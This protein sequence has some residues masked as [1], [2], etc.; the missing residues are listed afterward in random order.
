MLKKIVPLLTLVLVSRTVAAQDYWQQEVQYTIDVAL[1][2]Q[3]HSLKGSLQLNYTNHSPDTLRYIWFHLWPNA[4]K[5]ENTALARQL[6]ADKEGKKKLKNRKSAGSIDGLAFA[7]NGKKVTTAPD[8]LN[9][10]DVTKVVLNEPLLPGQSADITTPFVVKLPFYFSRSGYDGDQYMLCQWYP[11]P[12]VYDRKGWHAFPYLDQGEFYSEFG[13]FKVNITV[14]ADYIVG[15]TGTLL[16]TAELEQYKSV[17]AKNYQAKAAVAQYK[18]ANPGGNKTLQ[19]FGENIHDFAWF[20][21]KDVII[22][23]DSLQLPS[24]KVIDAFTWYQPNGNNK[25][26]N[27]IDYVEDAVRRYSTWIGEYPWPVVQAVEGPR[28]LSSGGMEYPMITLITSPDAGVEELDAVITHEVGHNWFY[29]ILASN[30]RDYP[31]MDEGI[32]SFY[33]FRYEA[34]KYKSNS[35]FGKSMPKEVKALPAEEL[36]SRV[37]NAL[38]SIPSKE[39]VNTSSTGFANKDDYGIVVYVKAATWLYLVEMALGR[40]GFDKAM[41]AYFET[42]KFKHPYPEDLKAALE[43]ASQLDLEKYFELLNKEGNF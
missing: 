26:N 22:Q 16:T 9:N 20:A 21:D 10:P 28:N 19:Y 3:Q 13:S 43:K 5:D 33:Q 15:A 2:V 12:A 29:G 36:L 31:W 38:N 8:S 27:S 34:E 11:K 40:E 25:W 4:Y 30:E 18:P 39:P 35:I 23:Y 42:W 24:G 17:G 32:N 6:A 41:Q 37:Y 14:P 7:V 1:D